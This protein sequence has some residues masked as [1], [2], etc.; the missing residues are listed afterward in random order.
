MEV[1]RTDYELTNNEREFLGL[2][3][4]E[5]HW[6]KVIFSGDKYRPESIL[7]F[8]D[9]IIKRHIVLTV[10]KYRECHYNERTKDRTVLLPR[11]EKGKEKRLT[12][13]V[14]EQR[15][16]LGVYVNVVF[17]G[18]IIG[19][20]NTQTTFYSTF[21]EKERQTDQSGVASII[22]EFIEQ[23]P[24]NHLSEI[25]SF[26]SA[27]RK[28]VKFRAGDYF[29]FKINRTEYGFGRLLLDVNKARKKK[30]L[31]KEHGLN[32]LMGPPV[33]VQLFAYK[34]SNK[35]TDLSI[36]EKQTTLPADVM[37]DNLLLYGEFEIIGNKELS[38]EEFDFPISYGKSLDRRPI[39]FLQ[40]G[41]IH[42]E[43]P[44]EKFNKYIT[45]EKPYDQNPYGYY[46]IGFRPSYDTIDIAKT[47]SN[48]GV[49]D[50]ENCNHYQAKHDLR[51][52][53][54][55]SVKDEI[56]KVFGLDPEKSY[57]EN[58]KLTGTTLMTDFLKKLK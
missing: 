29:A 49:F 32:L 2:D 14:L 56:F 23:S 18:L 43:L 53:K 44:K 45:G 39:V 27:K 15:Q 11:T 3:P 52:P 21:W 26:K 41:L 57:L 5:N 48:N 13:S 12:A 6:D 22:K 50:F 24:K 36:L 30:L 19:S 47:I 35:N 28:N 31:P 9:E 55:K 1:S 34:S 8:E 42:K 38:D 51:S 7:Y 4:I 25:N 33:I 20:Y 46:S 54:N 16:P 40:W 17:G 10:D 37:M 58:C